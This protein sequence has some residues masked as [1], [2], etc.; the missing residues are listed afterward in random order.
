ML[1]TDNKMKYNDVLTATQLGRRIRHS[2]VTVVKTVS[3]RV[4]LLLLLFVLIFH[5]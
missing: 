4:F 5:A 2:A 3:Q 1:H